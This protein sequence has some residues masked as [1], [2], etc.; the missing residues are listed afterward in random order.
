MRVDEFFSEKV[1]EPA[2][3]TL[4]VVFC[5]VLVS[6]EDAPY[7]G[8]QGTVDPALVDV[9]QDGLLELLHVTCRVIVT[10][11]EG[12]C[13]YNPRYMKQNWFN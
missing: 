7:P 12:R 13:E 2:V 9:V 3:G 10:V 4:A 11:K 6:V 5:K 1:H 8:V